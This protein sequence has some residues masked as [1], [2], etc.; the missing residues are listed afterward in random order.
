MVL[1]SFDPL[2]LTITNAN[3]P[4]NLSRPPRFFWPC[5]VATSQPCPD[6]QADPPTPC[7]QQLIMCR[8][9]F[10]DALDLASW[11]RSFLEKFRSVRQLLRLQTLRPNCFSHALRTRADL[12][13][14]FWLLQHRFQV[15]E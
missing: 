5:E 12:F 10:G 15:A 11:R 14:G 4:A 3:F 1:L 7:Q 2:R 8:P 13:R 9:C 6:D